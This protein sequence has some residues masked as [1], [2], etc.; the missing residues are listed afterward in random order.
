MEAYD[1]WST[2]RLR[3]WPLLF[4]RFYKL[5][6]TSA[7]VKLFADDTSLFSVVNYV[8]Y[9][10]STI[11]NDLTVI[12]DWVYHWKTFFNP[13]K[14]KQTQKVLFFRKTKT[15][16]LLP[17]V[18]NKFKFKLA[19]FKKHL[20][21]HLDS[22]LSFNEHIADKMN[23]AIKSKLQSKVNLLRK[24]QSISPRSSLFTIHK[25]FIQP[26]LDYGDVIFDQTHGKSLLSRTRS[27]QYNAA[28]PIT[29]EITG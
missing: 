5:F 16:I 14:N 17:L 22:K 8:N 4:P 26:G 18:F 23:K 25:S 10:A 9:S 24:L 1:S 3:T 15:A 20:G 19:S 27:V 12:Q 11:N 28:L 2:S 29:G 21:L 7:E 13:D 6:T